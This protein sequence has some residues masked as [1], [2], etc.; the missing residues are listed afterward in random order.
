MSKESEKK[1]VYWSFPEMHEKHRHVF[2]HFYAER[3][4]RCKQ[5][6]PE[7]NSQFDVGSGF[8]FWMDFCKS[9]GLETAGIDISE[10]AVN[11]CREKLKLDSQLSALNDFRFD[12]QFDLYTCCDVLEHLADPNIELQ[13]LHRAMHKDSLLFIQVPDVV[14]FKY[15][16][17]YNL[18][19][20]HHLWQFNY[21]S[22]NKLLKKNKFTILGSWHGIMGVVGYFERNEASLLMRLKWKLASK[23]RLGNRLMILC[24][25]QCSK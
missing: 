12:K 22:M 3:F 7:M 25:K 10:P 15:P 8:G 11:Y 9:K 17:G 6:Y 20:P 24:R 14:G 21:E 2:E 16:Y 13:V 18:N 23:F 5:F 19:L 1:V 4:D